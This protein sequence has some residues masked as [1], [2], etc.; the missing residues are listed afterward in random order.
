[1][2]AFV[3]LL[4]RLGATGRPPHRPLH[5]A[6]LYWHFVDVVWLVILSTLYLLP[7]AGR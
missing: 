2:L 3:A 7:A 5:N 6:S 1:M 4:P